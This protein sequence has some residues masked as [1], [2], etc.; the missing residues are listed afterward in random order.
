MEHNLHDSISVVS[1]IVPIVLN[2]DTEGTGTTVDLAGYETAEVV[3][4]IGDSGD[5]LSGSV[6]LELYIQESDAS[7]SGF[8]NAAA[9]DVEGTQGT[10]IDDPAEDQVVV[11]L[12]Y[13][14]SKRYIRAFIDTTGT[15]TSG[16]PCAAVVIRGRPRHVGSIA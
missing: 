11:A 10:L 9:A 7:G 4:A 8:A 1:T 5:T 3:F 2:N 13:K 12:G 15:H 14:G 6:K 16:T